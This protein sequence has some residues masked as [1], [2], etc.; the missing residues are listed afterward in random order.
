MAAALTIWDGVYTAAQ[1]DQGEQ[2]SVASCL[3][4]HET[5]RWAGLVNGWSERPVRELFQ[6][7]RTTMPRDNPRSL[8]RDEYA[9][10]VAYILE[11]GGAAA[12]ATP[13]PSDDASLDRIQVA[14]R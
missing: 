9:A 14:R 1:A 11:L 2:L 6:F 7:I 8:S 5:R 12:G 4:C 10:I 3:D 13:L